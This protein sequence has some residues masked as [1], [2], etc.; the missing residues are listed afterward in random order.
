MLSTAVATWTLQV[1]RGPQDVWE[2]RCWHCCGA[3]SM[4]PLCV[5]Q[6]CQYQKNQQG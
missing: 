5:H 1:S 3:A 4:S 6:G 2:V